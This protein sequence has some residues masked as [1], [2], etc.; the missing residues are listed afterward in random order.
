MKLRF[1]GTPK[2]GDTILYAVVEYSAGTIQLRNT[3]NEA[4]PL[5]MIADD[6]ALL[7]FAIEDAAASAYDGNPH[8]NA[9][10]R[11]TKKV[12]EILHER[13]AMTWEKL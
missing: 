13:T 3:S 11:V 9:T 8:G 7:T 12:L 10:E 2:A 6:A 5:T 4:I 1:K